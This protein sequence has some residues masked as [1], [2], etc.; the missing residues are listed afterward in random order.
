MAGLERRGASPR[1]QVHYVVDSRMCAGDLVFQHGRPMLVISWRTVDWKR[2]PYVC[3]PL[4]ASRLKAGPRPGSYIYDGDLM[5][6]RK[7]S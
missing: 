6:A 3:L 4:D 7:N 1:Q 5:P 2:V